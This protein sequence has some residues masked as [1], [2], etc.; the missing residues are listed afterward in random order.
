MP[1]WFGDVK[2]SVM[3]VWNGLKNFGMTIKRGV[4]GLLPDWLTDRLGMTV[5]GRIPASEMGLNVPGSSVGGNVSTALNNPGMGLGDIAY[6]RSLGEV[7]N[8]A[9][10]VNNPSR[11]AT[12]TLENLYKYGNPGSDVANAHMA[13]VMSSYGERKGIDLT[14]TE[15]L[16]QRD[17]NLAMDGY[18]MRNGGV[19]I[20]TDASNNTGAVIVNNNYMDSGGSSSSVD[21]HTHMTPVTGVYP[22]SMLPTNPFF[23][24][25]GQY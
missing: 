21:I 24:M 20:T 23:K 7:V 13:R 9:K 22:P 8:Y 11:Q 19:N 16:R 12:R 17:M 2:E 3:K 18:G 4:I 25:A 6:E 15:R 5:N 14:A 1:D 10:A